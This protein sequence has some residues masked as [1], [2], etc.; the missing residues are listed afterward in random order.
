[1]TFAELCE[2]EPRLRELYEEARSPDWQ[3][4]RRR[5]RRLGGLK[6]W[7]DCFRPELVFLVG[8]L[9]PDRDP[10][11]SSPAAYDTAYQ[12]ILAALL[13]RRRPR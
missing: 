1:M 9:R 13:G 7:Y 2:R 8:G 12:T 3:D 5:D 10:V 6:P 4:E 11:L